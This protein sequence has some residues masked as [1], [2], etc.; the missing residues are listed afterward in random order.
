M[1]HRLYV[2]IAALVLS[3]CVD[4]KDTATGDSGSMG[5]GSGGTQ[6]GEPS[7]DD[8][9]CPGA[10]LDG[11][12]QLPIGTVLIGAGAFIM[13]NDA[14]PDAAPAHA[15][16]ISR[17]IEVAITEVTQGQW[18]ELGFANPSQNNTCAD[19]PVEQVTWHEAAAFAEALSAAD[20]LDGC[21]TCAGAG[22]DTVCTPPADPYACAGWRL[23]T[24]AEWE[25][26]ATADSTLWAGSD[27]FT[28]VAW[29]VESVGQPCPVGAL[30]PTAAGIYDLS[31]NVSEWV[32]D[33][34][35][36]YTADD[37]RDPVGADSTTRVVRGGSTFQVADKAQVTAREGHTDT[38]PVPWRGFRLVKPRD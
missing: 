28:T 3:S 18:T 13:G 17:G 20:G 9:A 14:D 12:A 37:A 29:T 27:E 21:Y 24:E 35:S 34:Y 31:G 36:A 38:E 19:C 23:P 8:G 22:A 1:R 33:G 6:P 7:I 26:A 30:A 10:G 15:V 25:L 32:H 5:G 16:T 2:S 4:S 11:A